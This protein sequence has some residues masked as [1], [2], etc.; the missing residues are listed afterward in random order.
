[1]EAAMSSDS[2]ATEALIRR[3]EGGDERAVSELFAPPRPA[4]ADGQAAT[5][6]AVAGTARCIRRALGGLPG[7]G[8]ACRGIPG[9]PDDAGF[10]LAPPDHRT[11][12]DGPASQAS[13][14]PD[15]GCRAGGL[16]P[17]R[18]VA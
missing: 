3:V 11:T 9:E 10:P 1:M 15:A 5:R 14:C 16:A 18:S 17:P 2:S 6:P 4:A 7:C 12:A 8:Q 13:G